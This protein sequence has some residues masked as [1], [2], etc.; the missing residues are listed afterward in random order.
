[1]VCAWLHHA[2]LLCPLG[3]PL[4]NLSTLED[5]VILDFPLLFL[6]FQPP[7][8]QIIGPR[9]PHQP[10]LPTCK[11]FALRYCTLSQITMSE[12]WDQPSFEQLLNDDSLVFGDDSWLTDAIDWDTQYSPAPEEPVQDHRDPAH[13]AEKQR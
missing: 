3:P 10:N 4:H 1:M 11:P 9:T 6:F 2:Y 13:R 7:S 12:P 8:I 5:K